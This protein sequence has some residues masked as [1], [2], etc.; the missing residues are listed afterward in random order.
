MNK[1]INL[2]FLFACISLFCISCNKGPK[3]VDIE[4]LDTYTDAATKFSIQ[5]PKNW[6][7]SEVIGTRF[8]V[9][10]HKD[11]RSRFGTRAT[12]GFPGAK[13]DLIVTPL[14]SARTIDTVIAKSMILPSKY[15]EIADVTI[16]GVQGKKIAYS[17]PLEGGMFNGLMYIATKDGSRATMLQFEAFDD[18]FQKYKADFETIFKSLKLAV[19]LEKN[20]TDSVVLVEAEPPSMTLE[21]RQGD[22]FTLGIPDNF[23]AENIGKAGGAMKAWSFLGKRRG[24]CFIKI[25]M[26]DAS[27]SKNLKKIA[28]ENQAKFSGAGAAQKTTLSG[29]EAYKIDYKPAGQV[30]G[31]V[32]FAIKNNKLYRVTINWFTGEEDK[33]LPVFDKSVAS[34]KFQ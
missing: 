7:K 18:T 24:D 32:W 5:Y 28:D 19:A 14:D 6:L 1:I 4:G 15:Y 23:K 8:V 31:K 2:L 11:V 17:Y 29:E 21:T 33:F 13:I 16:D 22:G 10:S 25:E 34:F 27:K 3:P 9:F 26:F 12:E 20:K 30:K